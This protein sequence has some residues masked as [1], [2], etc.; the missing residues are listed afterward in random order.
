MRKEAF[1]GLL[2]NARARYSPILVPACMLE[3]QIPI[4]GAIPG[5]LEACGD[6]RQ[7]WRPDC[8]GIRM[9][10]LETRLGRIGLN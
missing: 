8:L 3:L 2:L 10:H 5:V 9:T 1:N 6:E 4:A 7:T